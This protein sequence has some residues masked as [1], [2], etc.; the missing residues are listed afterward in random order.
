MLS[1][2]W[3]GEGQ[4]EDGGCSDEVFE[5]HGTHLNRNHLAKIGCV[6]QAFLRHFFAAAARRRPQPVTLGCS[7]NLPPRGEPS[8]VHGSQ[9]RDAVKA[10]LVPAVT[11][12]NACVET[13][14]YSVGLA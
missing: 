2:G 3:R 4:R 11:S 13:A 5:F 6:F 9:P 14:A 8:P 10:P 7:Q 12:R 1:E